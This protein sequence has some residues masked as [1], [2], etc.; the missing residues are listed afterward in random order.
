M[1][2]SFLK[3]TYACGHLNSFQNDSNLKP[4]IS[5][6]QLSFAAR[7]ATITRRRSRSGG[8]LSDR[9]SSDHDLLRAPRPRGPSRRLCAIGSCRAQTYGTRVSRRRRRVRVRICLLS[10][11]P[12][13]NICFWPAGWGP[14][15]FVTMPGADD[16]DLRMTYCA[17]VV[18][19]LLG[20]WSCIDLPRALSYIHRCRVRVP[21]SPFKFF[22][23]SLLLRCM[24]ITDVRR[25][26]R[27]NATGRIARRTDILR[28]RFITPRP[29]RPRM[30]ASG[31][32]TARRVALDS[33]LVTAHAS[34][35]SGICR[36]RR[37]RRPYE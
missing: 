12:V 9:A 3:K 7:L 11:R 19:A 34:A 4:H 1:L 28:P 26:I 15:R 8:E 37:I 18:C 5:K 14:T 13:T 24:K 23:P 29:G 20:D 17:F 27:T 2:F 32:S 33:T 30:C 16:A 21:F 25:R 31:A 10:F 36:W 22:T 6:T 35:N